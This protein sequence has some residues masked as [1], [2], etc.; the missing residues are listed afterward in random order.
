VA[1]IDPLWIVQLASHLCMVTHHN[2]HWSAAAGRV[3]VE[4]KITLYGL[5]VHKRKAAYG[6][7]NP[8]EA[9]AIFIRSALV[10]E[11]FSPEPPLR[12]QPHKPS[13]KPTSR[14]LLESVSAD[15]SERP[16]PYPFLEHNRQIRQ[17]IETWQTRTRR[18]DLGDLD[19]ALFDF[20]PA[21]SRTSLPSTN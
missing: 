13:V 17:K 2:P 5:E 1:G 7:I 4:E 10:E 20:I 18:H 14:S 8:K 3:L 21:E 15:I 16:A 19:Q 12:S 11:D 6:N 9:T